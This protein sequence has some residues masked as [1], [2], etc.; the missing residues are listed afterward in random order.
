MRDDTRLK[1]VKLCRKQKKISLLT[2]RARLCAAGRGVHDHKPEGTGETQGPP[3]G[4][5]YK[6]SSASEFYQLPITKTTMFFKCLVVVFGATCVWARTTGTPEQ[7]SIVDDTP[8]ASDNTPSYLSDLRFVYKVYQECAA[9]DL[10]SCLKLKLLAALDRA[11]RTYNLEL[12]EGFNFVKDTKG[13]DEED[14]PK[15]EEEIEANLPRSLNE[16]EATLDGMIADKVGSF[17][18]SHSLQIKL[19]SSSDLARS[20]NGE[21]RGKKNRRGGYMMLLPLILGGTMVP[22]ALG[23]LALLAGKALIVSKLALVLAGIIGLK[24]LLS[25]GHSGHHDS[26]HVEVVSGHGSGWGRSYNKEDAQNLAYEA[27]APKKDR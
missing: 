14:S 19:P 17:L 9:T 8:R 10:S 13:T 26:G 21:E 20:F 25:S 11:S 27:Y 7:N 2:V 22:L 1:D 3:R 16:R 4:P 18:G 24:K 12:F 23:A 15:S 5:L 6:L